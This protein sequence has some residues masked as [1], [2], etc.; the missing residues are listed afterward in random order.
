MRDTDRE[1]VRLVDER[2][3]TVVLHGVNVVYMRAP[4]VPNPSQ[5]ERTSFDRDDVR[6]TF[7]GMPLVPSHDEL[8]R[9][10][11]HELHAVKCTGPVTRAS[12]RVP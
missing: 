8:P 9:G 10:H 3:R 11:P 1:W 5:G 7:A 12:R 4:Y 2:G 6:R